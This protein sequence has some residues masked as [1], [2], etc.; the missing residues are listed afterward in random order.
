MDGNYVKMV[1]WHL[2]DK[3]SMKE[4]DEDGVDE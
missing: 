3:M 1:K 4:T 2:E